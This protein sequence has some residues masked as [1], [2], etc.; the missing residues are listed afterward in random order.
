MRRG[1]PAAF[2]SVLVLVGLC[3]ATSAPAFIYWA[4]T[5][6]TIGRAKP[7]GSGVNQ[8]FLASGQACGVAVNRSHI[9][10]TGH[11]D[12][13]TGHGTI[14]RARLNGTH[15]Q[16]NLITG[17]NNP[18]GL[19]IDGRY[20]YWS[21]TAPTGGIGRARLDGSHVNRKFISTNGYAC[22]VAVNGSH[23][24]W[25]NRD[26]GTIGRANLSGSP[27]SVKQSFIGAGSGDVCG[28][29]VNRA[30]IYWADLGGDSIGRAAIDGRSA[31]VNTGF[32]TGA[33]NPCGL[34]V[35]SSRIYWANSSSGAIASARLNGT[36]VNQSLIT[37]NIPCWVAA[38]PPPRHHR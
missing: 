30:H 13:E 22:G 18:C 29:A 23:I 32:I 4:N 8:N 12:G 11:A 1:V 6:T 25:A 21:N 36:A 19:A 10:W 33:S 34:A 3:A 16:A 26:A 7:N 17:A 5:G 24:Y 15:R 20:V 2:F 38:S 27:A 9:Y 37:A 14:G 31:S 28:V 35:D